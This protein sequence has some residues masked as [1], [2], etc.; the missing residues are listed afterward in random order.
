MSEIAK[1]NSAGQDSGA[2]VQSI[3]GEQFAAQRAARFAPKPKEPEKA[4]ETKPEEKPENADKEKPKESEPK[5]KEGGEDDKGKSESQEVL[6][7]IDLSELSDED[8]TELA[9]KGKSGLLR[10]VAELTAKRK[11]AEEK[12]AEMQA[13]LKQNVTQKQALEPKIENNPLASLKTMEDLQA[14]ASE[15]QEVVEW[16]ETILDQNEHLA[17]SDIVDRINGQDVTKAQVKEMLRRA[18][19]DKDKH[20][21]ARLREI[22]EAQARDLFRKSLQDRASKELDWM[23]GE[24]ND[25]RRQYLGMLN[26]PRLKGLEQAQPDV[27]AQLPYILA[28]AANSMYGVRRSIPI[29]GPAKTKITPPVSPTP[30]VASPE[31][32]DK[33][34][35]SITETTKRFQ[36]T[37]SVSDFVAL[38]AQQIS[39][40]KLIK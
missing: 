1:P 26:D 20:L 12:L 25:V 38:R 4:P 7:Q 18:R 15:I 40:R 33:S 29:D 17:A 23:V 35:R 34:E 14:K 21:P 31:R 39:K 30:S 24:D 27:A 5:P 2:V 6:S 11:L 28:H 19:K 37:G 10:R 9:Q 32:V 13:S 3:T 22:Q 16:S 8:I 36:E